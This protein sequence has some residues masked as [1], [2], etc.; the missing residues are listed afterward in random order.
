MNGLPP[1][2]RGSPAP[3]WLAVGA[4]MALALAA[5][6]LALGADEGVPPPTPVHW[7]TLAYVEPAPTYRLRLAL[8]E[9]FGVTAAVVGYSLDPPPPAFPGLP[10]SYPPWPKL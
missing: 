5:P 1:E 4:V 7:A 9:L 8:E 6:T 3:R 10:G 2:L